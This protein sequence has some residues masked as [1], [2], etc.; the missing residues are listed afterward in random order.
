MAK[1]SKR[2]EKKCCNVLVGIWDPR[3]RYPCC[4]ACGHRLHKAIRLI[5]WGTVVLALARL[6]YFVGWMT[7]TEAAL[8]SKR[9]PAYCPANGS[10]I[11]QFVGRVLTDVLTIIMSAIAVY[12]SS[13]KKKIDNN[14]LEPYHCRMTISSIGFGVAFAMNCVIILWDIIRWIVQDPAC[15]ASE[16]LLEAFRSNK[17][18]R[19]YYCEH[20]GTVLYFL[21]WMNLAIATWL[22]Y[23][24]IMSLSYRAVLVTAQEF[25][26]ALMYHEVP[27]HPAPPSR[28][29]PEKEEPEPEPESEHEE[30]TKVEEEPQPEEPAEEWTALFDGDGNTYWYNNVTQ[31]TVWDLPSDEFEEAQ[32]LFEQISASNN[33]IDQGAIEAAYTRFRTS[34]RGS[35]T[36]DYDEF[37]AILQVNKAHQVEKLFALFDKNGTGKIDVQEFMVG[38]SMFTSADM[39]MKVKFAFTVFDKDNNGVITT[40]ELATILGAL[41]IGG[42]EASVK[43]KAKMILEQADVDTDGAIDYG[44]FV[45]I[46][47]RFPNI[48][49]PA[50]SLSQQLAKKLGF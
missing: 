31:E 8:A 2:R 23:A 20:G 6:A 11:P 22:F 39:E 37:C 1:K 44:E 34:A 36:I 26:T 29:A 19:E 21:F 25:G 13:W 4:C 9:K 14:M 40:E 30:E 42:D 49:F 48:L 18:R 35:G 41:H 16:D 15:N 45:G 17:L 46:S 5:A 28:V 47:K 24:F 10:C 38:L 7:G 43:R 3:I 50:V 27:V 33:N 32:D 12:G